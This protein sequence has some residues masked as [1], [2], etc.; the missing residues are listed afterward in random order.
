MRPGSACKLSRPALTSAAGRIAMLNSSP[1]QAPANRIRLFSDGTSIFLERTAEERLANQDSLIIDR[2]NLA[3][4][5]LLKS[6]EPAVIKVSCVSNNIPR[7]SDALLKL[8]NLQYLDISSNKLETLDGVAVFCPNLRVLKARN[9]LITQISDLSSLAHLKYLD[10]SDN[11]LMGALFFDFSCF[12]SSLQSLSLRNNKLTS[13]V[14]TKAIF[15]ELLDLNLGGNRLEQIDVD[16]RALP[17]LMKVDLG[18]N[19]VHDLPVLKSLLS[20]PHLKLIIIKHNSFCIPFEPLFTT[21]MS[22]QQIIQSFS[23]AFSRLAELAN[24]CNLA[25]GGVDNAS[26]L[27]LADFGDFRHYFVLRYK[28]IKRGTPQLSFSDVKIEKANFLL[29]PIH[30]LLSGFVFE[31]YIPDTDTP[32]SDFRKLLPPELL[33]DTLVYLTNQ[34]DRRP[35]ASEASAE[36]SDTE[37][38][39]YYST[40][41]EGASAVAA[42][43]TGQGFTN[44]AAP[45]SRIPRPVSE[46][47]ITKKQGSVQFNSKTFIDDAASKLMR[48]L[49]IAS[50]KRSQLSPQPSKV[51]PTSSKSFACIPRADTKK[52][53]ATS[54]IPPVCNDS[55]AINLLQPTNDFSMA[56]NMES[57]F[58]PALFRTPKGASEQLR[59]LS[60]LSVLMRPSTTGNPVL[61][62]KELREL[63]G[64]A[65][66][67]DGYDQIN[68]A[69]GKDQSKA[70]IAE[71]RGST[72]VHKS[73]RVAK[74]DRVS[75]RMSQNKFKNPTKQRPTSASSV[76]SNRPAQSTTA[77]PQ[78]LGFINQREA[79]FIKGL[80]TRKIDYQVFPK[81]TRESD[82]IVYEF[83]RLSDFYRLTNG[84]SGYLTDDISRQ[85]H[86]GIRA[87]SLEVMKDSQAAQDVKPMLELRPHKGK[88][89]KDFSNPILSQEYE[90]FIVG[91]KSLEDVDLVGPLST[92]LFKMIHKDPD[93]FTMPSIS[94]KEVNLVDMGYEPREADQADESLS[95]EI[96]LITVPIKIST[97]TMQTD[98]NY[99][100]GNFIQSISFFRCNIDLYDFSS[101]HDLSHFIECVELLDCG[102]KT[103]AQIQFVSAFS[104]LRCLTIYDDI[105]KRPYFRA[106][107]L[108]YCPTL[109]TI[110]DLPITDTDLARANSFTRRYGAF[111][112]ARQREVC[113]ASNE[114]ANSSEAQASRMIRQI[115]ASVD[116]IRRD[117]CCSTWMQFKQT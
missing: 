53:Y 65:C 11:Q 59:S 57:L 113:T 95:H 67:A 13:I 54:S 8:P 99:L 108:Y 41:E 71:L 68:A 31:H 103:L 91:V 110:N 52:S 81:R 4:F 37:T 21:R 36:G 43:S 40:D 78:T 62:G 116:G 22:N 23:D 77:L 6:A 32:S 94:V 15:P 3:T 42:G 86:G 73:P 104:R 105:T 1:R 58:T 107:C 51:I 17:K 29:K 2:Y 109:E 63:D 20:I 48:K 96:G 70:E 102:I 100:T 5:P 87:S 49:E 35:K 114:T 106:A 33:D 97:N 44:H 112:P 72:T 117:L 80:K 34:R 93:L 56:Q 88:D 83:T 12:P 111:I 115:T 9:C 84:A 30:N 45:A 38:Y 14:C 46:G 89:I 69:P 18:G 27:L 24:S 61:I 60:P 90:I 75:S 55:S 79:A 82:D 26:F 92:L 66:V 64:D 7:L 74:K 47:A 85:P 16:P 101:N 19:A 25:K 76:S 28:D 98:V 39:S 50:G 10:L